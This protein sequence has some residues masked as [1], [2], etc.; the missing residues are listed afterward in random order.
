MINKQQ[1]G[2]LF[3]DKIQL[4][5]DKLGFKVGLKIYREKDIR[6]KYGM[7]ITA[8]D[9]MFYNNK[10]LFCIQ[11]KWL[12]NTVSNKEFNHFINCINT[13]IYNNKE[14]TNKK[15]IALY[16]S[17]NGLSKYALE[18]LSFENNKFNTK[19]SKVKYFNI[20]NNDE[21]K[22]IGNVISIINE[23]LHYKK[24]F[25][26]IIYILLIYFICIFIYV[27]NNS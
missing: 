19:K 21:T 11:D 12:S 16:V 1:N 7:H 18:Q 13:L 14:F 26:I 8:I 22:L 4:N 25:I 20:Y 15:I 5:L 6:Q 3:E 17:N 24:K 10:I 23:Y 9:H 2:F 27:Y